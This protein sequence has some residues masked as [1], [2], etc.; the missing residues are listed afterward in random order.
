M[1]LPRKREVNAPAQAYPTAPPAAA[2]SPEHKRKRA[3][4]EA[5]EV[6]CAQSIATAPKAKE[7]KANL[8]DLG[9]KDS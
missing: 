5:A 3:D 1:A 9:L 8:E 2:E 4:T 7:V 6:L